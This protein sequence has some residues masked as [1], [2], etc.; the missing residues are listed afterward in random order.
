MKSTFLFPALLSS[1]LAF[2]VGS[3]ASA[4]YYRQAAEDYLASAEQHEQVL[5]LER[6]IAHLKVH[7]ADCVP[8]EAKLQ[9]PT[10]ECIEAKVR[11]DTIQEE[12]RTI[13]HSEQHSQEVV[14]YNRMMAKSYQ[15]SLCLL[16]PGLALIAA[17]L[18]K[19]KRENE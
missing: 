6:E 7:L 5:N 19:N 4:S 10:P 11:Y 2:G 14:Q 12:H 8:T 9:V 16:V 18:L 17:S 1:G 15:V 13:L 3:I